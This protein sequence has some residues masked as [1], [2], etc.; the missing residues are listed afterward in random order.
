[1]LEK[2]SVF[3]NKLVQSMVT[4]IRIIFLSRFFLHFQKEKDE[5]EECV[6]LGNGPGLNTLI[7][8]HRQFLG[9]KSL[10]CVNHFAET[11]LFQEL[12]P[13]VYVLGAPEM[14]LDDVEEYYFRKGENLFS[15]IALNTSWK[16]RMFIP[17]SAHKSKRWQQKIRRNPNISIQYYNPTPVEGFRWFC[18]LCFRDNLGMPRPH[19]V[20]I[21][22]IM[23]AINSSWSVIYLA[24]ADHS[25]LKDVWVT[26]N[27][28]V[29]LS[30]RHFY[31]QDTAQPKPMDKL[32][33]GS[34]RLHEVLMK[35]VYSFRGYFEIEAYSHKMNRKIINITPGSYIDAFE[36]LDI[37]NTIEIR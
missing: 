30:Q 14:W 8:K 13:A 35:W 6:I 26:E 2:I 36:R 1:M 34:R 7:E 23:I 27:N 31:D 9:G 15:E 24:G 20:M 33:K 19:N 18:N 21:P 4:K 12:K 37:D 25:W 17:W 16:M 11:R 3:F 10:I 22:S 32:G 29:L 28:E 5:P